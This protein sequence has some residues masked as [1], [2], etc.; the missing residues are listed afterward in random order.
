MKQYNTP[1]P[2]PTLST[3]LQDSNRRLQ[4][5]EMQNTDSVLP[6]AQRQRERQQL[7]HQVPLMPL[8]TAQ[9]PARLNFNLTPG[10]F[11]SV[12]VTHTT[13]HF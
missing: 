6:E 9:L 5:K 7:G 12:P 4:E 1:L 13:G 2:L 11:T 3:G 8:V 10:P